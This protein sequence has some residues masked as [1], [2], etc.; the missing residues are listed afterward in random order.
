MAA[1]SKL[2]LPRASISSV[3]VSMGKTTPMTIEINSARVT[4]ANSVTLARRVR[5][6]MPVAMPVEKLDSGDMSGATSMAPIDDRG[7]VG[8]QA[9]GG[10]RRR[11]HNHDGVV[12]VAA[13]IFLRAPNEF[14]L[15]NQGQLRVEPGDAM[16]NGAA[17]APLP[18][19]L[20]NHDYRAGRGIQQLVAQIVNDM[21][22]KVGLL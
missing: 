21:S 13:G 7:A 6:K 1:S 20:R 11:K 16:L 8:E 2:G 4:P 18:F 14:V 3:G 5:F 12:K 9:E 10:Q 22:F 15:L 17:D 19:D